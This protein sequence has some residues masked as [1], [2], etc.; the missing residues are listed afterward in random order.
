MSHYKTNWV[1]VSACVQ[2]ALALA[3]WLVAENCRTYQPVARRLSDAAALTKTIGRSPLGPR[4]RAPQLVAEAV[5]ETCRPA[6][7]RRVG[8]PSERCVWRRSGA[9]AR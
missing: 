2:G 6:R 8:F 5:P 3:L 1:S 4:P 9:T 7:R